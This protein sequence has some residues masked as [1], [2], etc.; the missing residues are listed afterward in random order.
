LRHRGQEETTFTSQRLLEAESRE[1]AATERIGLLESTLASI[2]VRCTHVQWQEVLMNVSSSLLCPLQSD[3]S[4]A[5]DASRTD[6]RRLEQVDNKLREAEDRLAKIIKERD[7]AIKRASDAVARVSSDSSAIVAGLREEASAAKAEVVR[8]SIRAD[9]LQRQVW[10]N[11]PLLYKLLSCTIPD[12]VWPLQVKEYESALKE[13]Q[14]KL[15]SYATDAS[16]SSRQFESTLHEKEDA[17]RALAAVTKERDALL[18]Q[19][20]GLSADVARL[21]ALNAN[22]ASNSAATDT[23]NRDREDALTYT[24]N[25]AEQSKAAALEAAARAEADRQTAE[26]KNVQLE[27]SVRQL[28][29]Q[30]AFY[31]AKDEVRGSY[32]HG[33]QEAAKEI[34]NQ[35]ASGKYPSLGPSP[36][37]AVTD[38]SRALTGSFFS[39]SRTR[40]SDLSDA[41]NAVTAVPPPTPARVEKR[42]LS[43]I[44]SFRKP[45]VTSPVPST[46]AA[47]ISGAPKVQSFREQYIVNRSKSPLPAPV[48]SSQ[49]RLPLPRSPPGVMRDTVS[50]SLKRLPSTLAT[51]MKEQ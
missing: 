18:S 25:A 16:K 41:P 26:S 32:Q 10:G 27:A 31:R 12:T 1:K 8:Q 30:L 40:L 28:S 17:K 44:P 9:T 24:L 48:K 23:V 37:T 22:L 51:G 15:N 45:V 3:L 2:Q 21:S 38:R 46:G 6:R 34:A 11:T 47:A 49:G 43:P 7:E 13:T 33:T 4:A 39:D 20:H 35:L 14:G 50:S 29:T 42:D 19:I 36:L 5:A